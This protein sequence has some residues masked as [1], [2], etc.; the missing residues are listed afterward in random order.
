MA[1]R[2]GHRLILLYWVK[3]VE[4][5]YLLVLQDY[6]ILIILFQQELYALKYNAYAQN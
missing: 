4:A 3:T 5:H 6:S 2:P 1:L